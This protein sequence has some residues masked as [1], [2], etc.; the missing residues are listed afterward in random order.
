MRPCGVLNSELKEIMNNTRII[1]NSW[2][3]NISLCQFLL[4]VESQVPW[5]QRGKV[6]T[7]LTVLRGLCCGPQR[8]ESEN[9]NPLQPI[10]H[11]MISMGKCKCFPS[12]RRMLQD[13]C[14]AQFLT[15]PCCRKWTCLVSLTFLWNSLGKEQHQQHKFWGRKRVQSVVLWWRPC[16]RFH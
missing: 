9:I 4:E 15:T 8:S 2:V 6:V 1:C 13:H 14:P 16:E 5:K 10:W 7:S 11:H 3:H 12:A